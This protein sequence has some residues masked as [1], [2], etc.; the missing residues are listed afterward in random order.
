VLKTLPSIFMA[1]ATQPRKRGRTLSRIALALA[2]LATAG[3]FNAAH[4][5]FPG[6]NGVIVFEQPG[7]PSTIAKVKSEFGSTVTTLGI[8]IQPSVSPSGKKIAYLS[9]DRLGLHVMNIDGSNAV[10]LLNNGKEMASP[11]WSPDGSKV[12]FAIA[13][14][15]RSAMELWSIKLN[16][17][18][19]TLVRSFP[20][21][22]PIDRFSLAWSP[23]G[24]VYTL[25]GPDN[26]GDGGDALY[27][28]D[29][30]DSGVRGLAR[31]DPGSSWAPDG[32]SILFH[33]DNSEYE[34]NPDGSNTRRLNP[35]GETSG[36]SSISPDGQ[37][38]AGS[39]FTTDG[40]GQ[41]VNGLA[42]RQRSDGWIARAW[43]VYSAKA[44]WSR[45]PKNCYTST[46]QG[47]GG[48]LAGDEFHA[49]NCAGVATSDGGQQV[50]A[51]GG[52]GYLYHRAFTSGSHGGWTPFAR[53]P[54]GGGNP[55]GIKA[56]KIAIA[57][58]KDGTSQVVIINVADDLVYHA[59]RYSS[60][61]WTGFTPLDGY[62]G[63]ANFAARDVAIT[64][65]ASSPTSPGNAQVIASG[66]GNGNIFYRVRQPDGNWWPF[67]NVPG[68]YG[69][70]QISYALAI[71]AAEDGYTDVLATLVN[72]NGTPQLVHQTRRPNS[73]WDGN[74]V[75]V[76]TP[77]GTIISIS[78]EVAVTRTLSGT[79]QLLFT[80][81]AGNVNFQERSSPNLPSSWQSQVTTTPI[82]STA[83]RAVSISAG[84][85]AGSTSQLLLTRTFPQ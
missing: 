61:N 18:G 41:P 77:A 15:N 46:P 67:T 23:S 54:G 1:P 48:I 71:S 36:I 35:L 50:I 17:T 21:A 51:V 52:D 33:F 85:T 12:G 44:D 56:K 62:A 69:N 31:N 4:A 47:G 5:T 16:G 66:L 58:A 10:Q 78:S 76:G 40:A 65:N 22:V 63:A 34:I 83:G 79:T 8:G 38:I 70:R 7:S 37:S 25:N 32:A 82:L 68:L 55:L 11:V 84:A 75:T 28:A 3:L 19:K 57:A 59:M 6:E 29:D 81:S 20:F 13:S 30:I 73:S 24:S 49:V 45:V 39:V 27:I 42:V 43:N 26:A 80:D 74:W 72:P 64:I 2:T 60:G 14:T 9:N 53:V